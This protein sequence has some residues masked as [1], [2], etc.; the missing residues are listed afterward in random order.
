G[1][2]VKDY[3][4]KSGNNQEEH[5]ESILNGV[6]TINSLRELAKHGARIKLSMALKNEIDE[7]TEKTKLLPDEEGRRLVYRNGYQREREIQAIIP[8]L[9]LNG[10]STWEYIKQY[11][12]RQIPQSGDVSEE[13]RREIANIL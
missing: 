13:R 9:Y 10:V 6:V 4:P 7:Y 1:Y 5:E 8:L 2:A 3:I 12:R 11:L